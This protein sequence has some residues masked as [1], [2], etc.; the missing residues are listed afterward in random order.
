VAKKAALIL[1]ILIAAGAFFWYLKSRSSDAFK[2]VEMLPRDAG[3]VVYVDMAALRSVGLL[4]TLNKASEEP[5]YRK[6]VEQSG[7]DYSRDLEAVAASF[8]NGEEFGAARGRFNWSKLSKYATSQGG[9]CKDSLCSLPASRPDFYISF[10]PLRTNVLAIAVSKD[11][12]AANKIDPPHG[13]SVFQDRGAV[14]I[15]AT[16]AEFEPGKSLPDGAQAFL[17]PLTKTRRV[18]FYVGQSAASNG[19]ELRLDAECPSSASAEDLAKQLR[20]TTDLLKS[21]L[22]RQKMT[23]RE[24]DLSGLLVSG[25]FTAQNAR[26]SGKWPLNRR[27]VE[28]LVAGGN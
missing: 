4:S 8:V 26:V 16:G 9:S 25:I 15:S 22:A 28:S 11:R 24:D 3:T 2:L 13:V 17:S 27:F 23:P 21:M 12:S 18:A 10:Y 19:L 6:F 1:G 5:D 20:N 14:A 7:F